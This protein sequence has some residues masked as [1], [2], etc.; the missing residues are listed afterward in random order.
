M[1]R[2]HLDDH[3]F[4]N[5]KTALYSAI[6][7]LVCFGIAETGSYFLL[8]KFSETG[9]F[10]MRK[11]QFEFHPFLG[12]KHTNNATLKTTKEFGPPTFIK[13]DEYGRSIT[14]L[15]FEN[16]TL[17]IVVTGGSS[18]F[19]VGATSN[20]T[21]TPSLLE[22]KIYDRYGIKAEV[23]NLGVRSYQSFQELLSVREFL[24]DNKA[25]IVI[26]LSG[27]NDAQ[28]AGT[29]RK[30][31]Y[32]LL[33]RYVYENAV[34]LMRDIELQKPVVENVFSFLRQYSHFL[35]LVYRAATRF[36]GDPNASYRSL[37]L[38]KAVI[39]N[40]D[41]I[42]E[43]AKVSTAHYTML[44]TL[45]EFYGA[46]FFFV[47]QPGAYTWE[48][49]PGTIKFIT[50]DMDMHT[51]RKNYMKQF[52]AEILKYRPQLETVDMQAIMDSTTQHPYIDTIHYVDHGTD[53][54]SDAL[55]KM[56][57]P[58]LGKYKIK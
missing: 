55:L 5:K 21:T 43:R 50:R 36:V 48:N 9:T 34:P 46:K 42:A 4:S 57:E 30:I 56:L 19:G 49:Y 26:S 38:D 37:P 15:Q 8:A 7:I 11:L 24:L 51:S 27:H 33:Q 39:F 16:P 2:Q 22:K 35:D 25:D 44:K 45:S 31:K 41:N 54:L 58:H 53:L 52:Y 28:Y 13:T 29:Q 23:Y 3:K 10:S 47:L 6:L 1:S 32:G 20:A 12:F 14:P 40:P 17:R 18:I